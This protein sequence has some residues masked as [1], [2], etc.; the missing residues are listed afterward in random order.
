MR[1][2]LLS[3]VFLFSFFLLSAQNAQFDNS[4]AK[5]LVTTNAA[6]IGLSQNDLN[7]YIVSSSYFDQTGNAQMVYLVQAY[8]GL[9]VRNQML[10]LSFRDGKLLSKAGGFLPNV[11]QLTNG[12]GA[13][14][15]TS[16]VD[17]VRAAITESRLVMPASISARYTFTD[18]KKIDFGTLSRSINPPPKRT[19][20]V[21][22]NFEELIETE[23]PIELDVPDINLDS[24]EEPSVLPKLFNV[25]IQSYVGEKDNEYYVYIRT[26]PSTKIQLTVTSRSLIIEGTFPQLPLDNEV[27]LTQPIISSFS[28]VIEFD[29]D[30]DYNSLN[31]NLNKETSTMVIRIKKFTQMIISTDIIF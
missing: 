12:K 15:G 4:L 26:I 7:N 1:K 23:P 29:E 27:K 9:P 19:N 6:A 5:Q 2:I 20:E 21:M 3:L 14:A 11:D 10:V 30:I 25:P 31:Q 17:A 8:K 28:K 18:T 24:T 16:A 22:N 13:T